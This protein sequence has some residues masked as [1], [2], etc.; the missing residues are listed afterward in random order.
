M[1]LFEILCGIAAVILAL[2]YF[3]TLTFDFW[4]SRG[5]RG[6]RPIPGFGTLKDVKLNRI[7]GGEHV[8]E[9]Y[10]VY[11]DEPV[12]G[13]F[14]GKTPILIVKDLDLIKDVLIKDFSVFANRGF[15]KTFQ[16]VR[17]HK[18]II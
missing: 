4:K 15:G 18:A 12:I 5:V 3:F 13:I 11:K 14:S 10:K 9:L 2:Y 7:S 16:K 1:E 17:I 6:P 8:K